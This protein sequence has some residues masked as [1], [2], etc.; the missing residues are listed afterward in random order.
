[1]LKRRPLSY[2]HCAMLVQHT[3][4]F[5]LLC[6]AGF[7]IGF[8]LPEFPAQ[9]SYTV[10]PGSKVSSGGR[11]NINTFTCFSNESASQR[12]A[13][14]SINENRSV[15]T[16]VDATLN[17]TAKSLRCG[18][19]SMDHNLYCALDAEKHP[20]IIIELEEARLANGQ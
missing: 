9:V 8:S 20:F 3:I 18:H 2:N 13:A 12:N 11:T 17:V 4:R 6:I 5:L 10:L 16:F 19:E 15:I 1:M 14:F 7:S